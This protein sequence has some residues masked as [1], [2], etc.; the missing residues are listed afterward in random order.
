MSS[1]QLVVFCFNLQNTSCK[2]ELFA[3]YRYLHSNCCLCLYNDDSMASSF[4]RNI[5]VK[6][7]QLSAFSVEFSFN[8]N[9]H[10]QI[11]GVAMG[12]P[13]GPALA[14]IFVG[15]QEAKLFNIAKRPLLYFRY[16]DDT[17]AVFNNEKDCNTFLTHLNSLHLSLRFTYEKKSNHSLP[18]LD[19]LVERHDSEF[20]TS[21]YRKPTFAGQYLRWNFFS[22]QKRKMNLIGTLV[23]R[24]LMICSKKKLD[25]ELGKI[26][27]ILLENGYP[28]HAINSAFKRKLQQLNSNSVHTVEKCPVYL[29]II[30][31][32]NVSMKFEKQ[33]TSVVKR[34][35]F[36]VK[37]HV[38]FNTR[39]LLPATKKDVLPSHHHSNVIYEFVC[40]SDSRYVGRTSQRLEE[41][42]KQHLPRSIA[43]PPASHNRQSLSHSCKANIRPQQ[44][45]ESAIGQHLLDNA[46]GALLYNNENFFIITRG[47][48]CFHLSA[49]EATF[50]K[51]LNLLLCKQKEFVYS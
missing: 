21:V 2:I 30:W 18:F 5:F 43:N 38:I 50:I 35:F 12:S 6:L 3:E 14:N 41:R 37:P 27:S 16:V 49:L 47:R 32:G 40:H 44:F 24:A 22:P 29:H 42:I 7:M 36:S 11:D 13:L 15:Y 34:C 23:H 19:V 39:Q 17:F 28:E 45:H 9:M 46:Q 26:R 1:F 10:R 8:N 48:S 31:I 33:I 20:L 25:T 51:S 4:P